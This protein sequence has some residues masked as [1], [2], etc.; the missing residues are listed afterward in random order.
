MWSKI[1]L[2]YIMEYIEGISI[3]DK[4]IVEMRLGKT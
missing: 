4:N 2:G 3:Y 1:E